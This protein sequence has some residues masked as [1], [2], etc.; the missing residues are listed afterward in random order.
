MRYNFLP[1]F[2]RRKGRITK[3]Q[4]RNLSYLADYSLDDPNTLNCDPSFDKIALEIGSVTGKI[5]FPL[6]KIKP[7]HYFWLLK[8]IN[9][10]LGI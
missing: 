6:R 9:L 8:F 4:E 2:A 10:V 5:F 3:L 7:I 1:S